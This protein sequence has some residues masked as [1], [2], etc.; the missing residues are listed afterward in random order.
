MLPAELESFVAKRRSYLLRAAPS[1]TLADVL[2][3]LGGSATRGAHHVVVVGA[4]GRPCAVVTATD[5]LR[6]I[7]T[8]PPA[9]GSG[10]GA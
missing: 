2:A 7:C 8:D 9:A 5:I 10:A 6:L 4:D 3:M 1:T